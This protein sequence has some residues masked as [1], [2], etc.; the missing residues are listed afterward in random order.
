MIG[1]EPIPVTLLTGFLGSG[2]T[3][4]LNHLVREPAFADTLVI[5]NEFGEVG[6][7]HLLVAHSQEMVI[8]LSSGC[9]CCTIRGDLAKTLRDLPWRFARDG[10]CQFNR[11]LIESTGLADPAPILHTLLTA[12]GIANRFRLD[13]VIATVDGI[14][15]HQQL[16]IHPEALKQSAMADRLLV[17]KVD[18][19]ET[20]AI[21][22]LSARLSK[23]NPGAPIFPVQHGQVSPSV[24]FGSGLYDPESK[25]PD[26]RRWLAAEHYRPVASRPSVGRTRTNVI[27]SSIQQR[28]DDSIR[29][30]CVTFDDPISSMG[31]GTALQMLTSFRGEHIL[32]AKGIINLIGQ[33]LPCVLH[34]VQHLI[35]PTVQLPAWPDDDH[36][37]HLV[38]I[39]RDLEEDF[40]RQ[41]LHNF[42]EASN[43]ALGSGLLMEEA[44][45]S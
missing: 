21:E 16:D 10:R 39:V 32:R 12:S 40:V 14:L 1:D 4:V 42:I 35:Y 41:T 8:E 43:E 11:V 18:R 25:T 37:T 17:T 2:K 30:F 5:I 19:V 15:G 13:G 20:A 22:S 33:P 31:L 23:I 26:V 45:L 28:H 38:F 9:F 34:V 36:R 27:K 44:G 6:L 7:D 24:V 3:T 29:S